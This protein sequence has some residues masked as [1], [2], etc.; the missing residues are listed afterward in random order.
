MRIIGHGV[1]LV[2]I[3]RIERLIGEHADRFLDRC[4]TPQERDYCSPRRNA[5]EH[6]AARFAAKEAV[7]KA[8]G[9]GL[10]DGISWTDV[11]VNRQPSG[12]P[13]VELSGRAMEI[14]SEMGITSFFLSL[15]HTDTE[16]LASVIAV[17]E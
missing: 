16:A 5:G 13:T 2:R 7:L 9:K 3:E 1:D 8:I 6:F 11:A 17:G 15:S 12:Q 4:F 10:A 14:A